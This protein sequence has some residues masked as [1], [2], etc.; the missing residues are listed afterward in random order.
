[1]EFNRKELS[2]ILEALRASPRG[3]NVTEVAKKTGMNRATVAKYLEMLFVSG[4]ADMRMFGMSKVYYASQRMPISAFLNFS[5][6][7]I[8]VLDKDSRVL[9]ANDAF[10]EF[11]GTQ[12]E[13]VV[14]KYINNFAFPLKFD[15]PIDKHIMQAINGTRTKIESY[16]RKNGR[17]YYFNVKLVPLI[18][19][20]GEKGVTIIF[21]DITE[22]KLAE[23]ALR[24]SNEALE[25]KV[26]ERTLELEKANEELR[27]TQAYL[28]EAQQIAR[29]GYW[30][31]NLRTKEVYASDEACRLFA[32]D[33]RSG[34]TY[35][36]FSE[37]VHP[38]DVPEVEKAHREAIAGGDRFSLEFRVVLPD[39][40][41]RII[42][43]VGEV[44]RDISGSVIDIYG[45]FQDITGRKRAEEALHD[46]EEQFRAL[47]ESSKIGI[48]LIQGDSTIY[49]NQ[50]LADM[51]GYTVEECLKMNFWDVFP[52]GMGEFVHERAILRQRGEPGPS[53]N[54]L[55]L[56]KKNG[57]AVWLDCTAAVLQYKG[58][59]AMLVTAMDV[60]ERKRVEKDLKESEEK[61]RNLIVNIGVLVWEVGENFLYTFVSPRSRAALGYE[62]DELVGKSPFA[63]M[64]PEEA[65]RVMELIKPLLDEYKPFELTY[66]YMVRKDGSK[67]YFKTNAMPIFDDVGRFK[68]YR[69]VNRDITGGQR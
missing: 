68:G 40:S 37:R 54:E 33:R 47:A 52:P 5:S 46:S 16:Y 28:I 17:G 43:Y 45:T 38:D 2:S 3:M 56:I 10:F 69:G 60:T 44:R 50:A 65:A 6:D 24:D 53:R 4:H 13:D 7:L 30:S 23:K 51:S 25:M 11:T 19:D 35:R 12:R 36:S 22:K 20:D 57:E 9:N 59:P 29:L 8:L 31:Y 67:V 61:Y 63:L 32:I 1:M 41:N 18:F 39:G 55:M 26:R 48:L 49:V 42:N 34:L 58:K 21:E 64:V 62:P 15:P 27:K 66:Y 14:H